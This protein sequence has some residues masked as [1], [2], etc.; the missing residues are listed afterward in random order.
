MF[1]NIP[2]E[3]RRVSGSNQGFVDHERHEHES[4]FRSLGQHPDGRPVNLEAWSAMQTEVL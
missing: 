1:S 4:P 3:I 2:A